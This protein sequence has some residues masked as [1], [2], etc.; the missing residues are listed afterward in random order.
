MIKNI[1]KFTKNTFLAKEFLEATGNAY[2]VVSQAPYMDKKGNVGT[3]GTTLT[4]M[5]LQDSTDYGVD[6]NTGE[7]RDNNVFETFDVTILNGETH[8]DLKKGDNIALKDF[9]PDHS[10]VMD[11]SLILRFKGYVKLEGKNK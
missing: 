10:Y 8:L 6:K 3:R 5:I 4:L 11:Y 1:Y 9:D 2:R 7:Q